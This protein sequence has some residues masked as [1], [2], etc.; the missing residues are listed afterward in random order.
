MPTRSV[1]D[2]Y[3]RW[4]ASPP[5]TG[6][7]VETLEFRGGS[8]GEPILICNRKDSPLVAQ[9]E[10]GTPRTF[11]PLSFTISKPSIR[12]SSEYSAIARLDALNGSLLE[13]F[14]NI[15][16]SE[17]TVPMH[18]IFRIYIDPSMLDRP[19]WMAPL[20]FRVETGKVGMDAI[21]MTL[22]G[23][24]LATKRAGLYYVLER[25]AGLRPY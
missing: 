20:R 8:L 16:S 25:F 5:T 6:L 18:A 3:A 19:C 21:E 22:V 12:N 2:D 10:N 13:I 15:T 11:L 14:G 1:R 23:G 17:L 9:D 4:L 24:R 7:P